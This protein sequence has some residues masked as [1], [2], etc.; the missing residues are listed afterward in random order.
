MT[1]VHH[2]IHIILCSYVSNLTVVTFDV[3]VGHILNL[4]SNLNSDFMTSLQ[5]HQNL[6]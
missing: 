6:Y 1:L 5:M 2:E 3:R 4:I